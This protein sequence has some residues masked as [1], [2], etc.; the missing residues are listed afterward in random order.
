MR[1]HCQLRAWL[2]R[3][4]ASHQWNIQ[5]ADVEGPLHPLPRGDKLL[6]KRVRRF[7]KK[8]MGEVDCLIEA[9][10]CLWVSGC[11]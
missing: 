9:V 2:L 11:S 5:T 10:D 1:Q 8:P 6:E 4:L 7:R 3:C